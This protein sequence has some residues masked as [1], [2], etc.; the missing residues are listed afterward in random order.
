MLEINI[1]AFLFILLYYFTSRYLLKSFLL[2]FLSRY[3]TI[4]IYVRSIYN[5]KKK[6]VEKV[7]VV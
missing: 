2:L 7:S 4:W 5:K 6:I 1:L 3:Y